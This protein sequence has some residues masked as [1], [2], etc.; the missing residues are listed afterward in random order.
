MI[1]PILYTR[2]EAIYFISYSKIN[3]FSWC[4]GLCILTDIWIRVTT[5]NNQVIG[6]LHPSPKSLKLIVTAPPP[7]PTP[8]AV[9]LLAANA[10]LAP[11]TRSHVVCHLLG[12]LSRSTSAR[13]PGCVGGVPRSRLLAA[14]PCFVRA[15][16]QSPL[17]VGSASAGSPARWSA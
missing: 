14:E 10:V 9:F 12:R 16:G 4:T 13:P 6:Q 8:A 2:E 17:C 5:T 15:R 3:F 7:V 11:A 1:L